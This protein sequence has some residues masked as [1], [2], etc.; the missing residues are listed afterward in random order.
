MLQHHHLTITMRPDRKQPRSGPCRI[1]SVVSR[2]SL[3]LASTKPNKQ[4]CYLLHNYNATFNYHNQTHITTF[5]DKCPQGFHKLSHP[6]PLFN[7]FIFF[8]VHEGRQPASSAPQIPGKVDRHG[9]ST[10]TISFPTKPVAGEC[11]LMRRLL[12]N[13]SMHYLSL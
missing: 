8:R 11:C 3:C 2:G 7:L 5:S 6:A 4:P 10:C 12:Q 13:T 1:T 9:A